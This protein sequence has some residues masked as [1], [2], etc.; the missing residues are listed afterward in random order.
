MS[1]IYTLWT[2]QEGPPNQSFV[3]GGGDEMG[4]ILMFWLSTTCSV[5]A[6]KRSPQ[7]TVDL[8]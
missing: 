5:M 6:D 8:P 3:R 4:E 7:L 2:K 1:Q